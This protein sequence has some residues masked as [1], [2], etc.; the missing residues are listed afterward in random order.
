MES[1]LVSIANEKHLIRT[2]D[3]RKAFLKY[4]S[5]KI[6]AVES[7]LEA[8]RRANP[9]ET[10]Y[11]YKFELYLGTEQATP[12]AG[13]P[14]SRGLIFSDMKSSPEISELNQTLTRFNN[15]CVCLAYL[16]EIYERKDFQG[17]FN[18][19]KE[20]KGFPVSSTP[21]N[22]VIR[23]ILGAA[24]DSEVYVTLSVT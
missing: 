17:L 21:T 2:E 4:T 5:D 7:L 14:V 11:P 1:Q 19:V 16:S 3:E 12:S 23:N 10:N 13:G 20:G 22:S 15:Y 18:F 6:K 24:E 8:E 9:Q